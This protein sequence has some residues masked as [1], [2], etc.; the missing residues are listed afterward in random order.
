M[1]LHSIGTANTFIRAIYKNATEKSLREK[2]LFFS[3]QK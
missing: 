2:S 3:S 1:I